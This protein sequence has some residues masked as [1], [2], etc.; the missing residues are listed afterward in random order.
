MA[1]VV[2]LAAT[3]AHRLDLSELA[4]ILFE[5]RLHHIELGGLANFDS[6]GRSLWQ[7]YS[8]DLAVG[9]LLIRSSKRLLQ[10]RPTGLSQIL[11]TVRSLLG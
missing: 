7:R 6:V 5:L 10:L 9:L 2:A 3:I 8:L 4:L 1:C 11:V